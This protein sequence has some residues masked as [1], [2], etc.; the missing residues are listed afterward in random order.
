MRIVLATLVLALLVS[1]VA[2]EPSLR[3]FAVV[4]ALEVD[5]PT[6]NKLL[7][8]LTRYDADLDKLERTRSELK[9]R[10]ITA[11]NADA[12]GADRLL[13]DWSANQRS[14]AQIEDQLVARARR[15]LPGPKAV[16]LLLLIS[17]TE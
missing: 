16:H 4:D 7:D 9:R 11:R 2:A 10:I 17:V 6:A 5:E 15:L 12:Q 14:I 8:I 1:P 3:A 13:H